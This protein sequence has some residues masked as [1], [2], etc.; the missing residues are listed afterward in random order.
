M[1]HRTEGAAPAAHMLTYSK[2]S[3]DANTLPAKAIAY[4]LH[5]GFTQ[6]MTDAAAATKE[7]KAKVLVAAGLLAEGH[8]AEDYESCARTDDGKAA[9]AL[10]AEGWREERFAAILKGEVGTRVGGGGPRKDPLLRAMEDIAEET[11]RGIAAAKGVAMPK[12]EVLKKALSVI[13]ERNRAAIEAKAKER[14]EQAKGLA[15]EMGDLF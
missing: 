1:E 13:I 11:V 8:T 14:L 5:N 12:G 10:A 3:I 9:L 2:W 15:E 4:L 7:D 6:S